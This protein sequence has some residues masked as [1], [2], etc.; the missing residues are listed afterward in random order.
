M[1]KLKTFLKTTGFIAA[2]TGIFFG[3]QIIYVLCATIF[4][5]LVLHTEDLLGKNKEETL[6]IIETLAME[7]ISNQAYISFIFAAIVS[8][9]IFYF[10]IKARKQSIKEVIG[11][12]KINAPNIFIVSI[13]GAFLFLFISFLMSYIL[14]TGMFEESFNKAEEMF[15]FLTGG[16]VILGFLAIVVI[17]PLMEELLF[18]GLILY[19]LDKHINTYIAI[20]IQAVLFGLVHLNFYQLTYT[21]LIGIILGLAYVWLKSIWAPIIIHVVNNGLSFALTTFSNVDDSA[22]DFTGVIYALWLFSMC[23][24]VCMMVLIYK[25]RKIAPKNNLVL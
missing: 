8:L 1:I 24:V 19:E 4:S 10:I 25:R 5:T 16:N 9:P 3:S 6:N 17:G 12:H 14:Q 22:V 15:K 13:L 20:I 18:R 7:N 11:F 2:Y 23:M 21:V